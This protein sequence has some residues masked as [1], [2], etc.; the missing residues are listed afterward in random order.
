MTYC[1]SFSSPYVEYEK[2]TLRMRLMKLYK[3]T[4]ITKYKKAAL[5]ISKTVPTGFEPVTFRLTAERSKPTEL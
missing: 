5:R 2:N 4:K 3:E 1:V